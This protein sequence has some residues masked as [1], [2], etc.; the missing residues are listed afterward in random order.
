MTHSMASRHRKGE[1]K[2]HHSS[3]HFKGIS[4]LSA[5]IDSAGHPFIRLPNDAGD[6]PG[7]P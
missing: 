3:S 7:T 6:F 4:A 2:K 1:S 5:I